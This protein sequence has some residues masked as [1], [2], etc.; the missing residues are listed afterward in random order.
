LVA[1]TV[2]SPFHVAAETDAILGL[3]RKI[4]DL[5][6]GQKA[7]YLV[8]IQDIVTERERTA[9]RTDVATRLAADAFAT[10][11]ETIRQIGEVARD[12]GVLPLLHPHAGTYLE[13]RDEIETLD[14]ALDHRLDFCIDTGHS[15][16]AGIDPVELLRALGTRARY[17]H[18]KD[19]NS[20]TLLEARSQGLGFWD[21]YRKGIF[22]VLGQGVVDF[23][24]ILRALNESGYRGWATVEQDAQPGVAA[25]PIGAAK[26]SIEFLQAMTAEKKDV[27]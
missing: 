8:I 20:K 26:A 19:I 23:P 12:Y 3:T 18:M 7:P 14:V 24:A 25:D 9:G 17:V 2:M 27:V 10:Q 4:C 13:F 15:V 16:Y 1:G 22:C 11:V 21:A 6:A 5:L